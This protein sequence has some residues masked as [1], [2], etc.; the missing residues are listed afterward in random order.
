VAIAQFVARLTARAEITGV[1]LPTP[2][3]LRVS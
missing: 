1:D 2:A 3:D